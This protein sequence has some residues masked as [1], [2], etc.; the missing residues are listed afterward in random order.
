MNLV[1]QLGRIA[2]REMVKRAQNGFAA[3]TS[4]PEGGMTGFPMAQPR[5]GSR[6]PKAPPPPSPRTTEV[7]P[8]YNEPNIPR[9]SP[10]EGLGNPRYQ[11]PPTPSHELTH[12]ALGS[13]GRDTINQ[14][15]EYLMNSYPQNETDPSSLSAPHAPGVGPGYPRDGLRRGRAGRQRGLPSKATGTN[16]SWFDQGTADFLGSLDAGLGGAAR[17]FDRS[18]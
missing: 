17:A 7:P 6:I 4:V 12:A 2:A 13:P 9:V 15:H 1:A 14:L 10:P 3:P 16:T 11:Q 8:L 18:R 5:S